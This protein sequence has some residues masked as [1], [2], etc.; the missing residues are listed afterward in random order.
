MLIVEK[1][2]KSISAEAYKTLRTNIQYSSFD[3][4]IKTILV[5]STIPGEG[6]STIAGNL[7]LSFAQQDKKVLV[8]DCDLR[9]P[10]LHKMFKLSNFKGLS[11]VIVGNSDLEKAMYNYRDNF[12]ILTSGKIPPNP[13]EILAS[14]AMTMLLEKLK[15]M[16]DI[17][18]IDSAP[19]QAVTDAQIISNKVDGTLLVIR[20]GLTKREAILQ[21]KELLNQVNAKILGVVLN[22]AENNSEKHYYYY[23][24]KEES[25]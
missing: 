3:K 16:Y 10:A 17:I 7:A 1:N 6:K 13:S 18:I 19:L 5:T 9:K 25:R 14:N 12:D 23:G 8:I 11:D 4:E 24:S 15:T 22:G 21:A 2:S 20:A